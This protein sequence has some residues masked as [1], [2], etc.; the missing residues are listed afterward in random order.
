MVEALL[1]TDIFSEFVKGVNTVVAAR[2]ADYV[3]HHG[4]LCISILTVA[5]VVRG[6][7]KAG[8]QRDLPRFAVRWH[9]LHVLPLDLASAELAG[10]ID[11]DLERAGQPIGR[12]DPLIAAIALHHGRTLVTGN[13]RH[14]ARV[15][16]L[17][18]PLQLDNWRAAE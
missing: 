12:V 10:Q 3:A 5:E 7:Q 16:A 2:A 9:T 6:L 1:D 13:Q 8:R 17:G 18:Y 4:R 14:Y 11:G 15:Q